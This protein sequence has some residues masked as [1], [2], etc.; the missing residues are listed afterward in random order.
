MSEEYEQQFITFGAAVG[1]RKLRAEARQPSS[2]AAVAP[3]HAVLVPKVF[4]RKM[5]ALTEGSLRVYLTLCG[6]ADCA[7]RVT[8]E[9][10]D[11]IARAA[12]LSG[13]AVQVAFA[14]LER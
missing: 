2:T 13:R 9:T 5:H 1:R 10:V 4:L 3:E 7:G 12:R 11:Q 8:E 6:L 14:I